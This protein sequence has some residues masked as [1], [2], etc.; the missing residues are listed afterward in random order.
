MSRASPVPSAASRGRWKAYGPWLAAALALPAAAGGAWLAGRSA[1]W[2]VAAL[3]LGC[4]VFLAAGAVKDAFVDHDRRRATKASAWLAWSLMVLG[5]WIGVGLAAIRVEVYVDNYSDH[6]VRL[7]LNGA[8]WLAARR[9]DN[10]IVALSPDDYELVVRSAATGDELDRMTVT[11]DHR[12]PFLL[13]VL[14]AHTYYRGLRKYP[15]ARF[16]TRPVSVQPIGDKWQR[17]DVDYPFSEPPYELKV[18]EGDE[19]TERTY[20]SRVP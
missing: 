14:G 12:G 16:G 8:P 1:L 19:T 7:E 9:G 18:V 6:D 20:L 4:G 2:L 5:V 11:V 3:L 15:S 13:N 17:L 10:L